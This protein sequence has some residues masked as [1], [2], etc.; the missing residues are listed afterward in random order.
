MKKLII[1]V[2]TFVAIASFGGNILPVHAATLTP[3]EQATLQQSLD[4][5]KAQLLQLESQQAAA[6]ASSPVVSGAKLSLTDSAAVNTALTS[7]AV[8]L[9]NLQ[10]TIQNNP[11]IATANAQGISLALQ[12]IGK[13]LVMIGTTVVTG[14]N[15]IAS[16]AP[17]PS[18]PKPAS[19]P[20]VAMNTPAP[21]PTP[22][23]GIQP[24][25][26]ATGNGTPA[27]T[28][29]SAAPQSAQVAQV[30]NA[31]SLK[32]IAWPYVAVG[33]LVILAIALWLWW[34]SEEEDNAKGKKIVPMVP[35]KPEQPP[36][37]ILA[38]SGKPISQTPSAPAPQT[39]LS[40]A[41]S[42]PQQTQQ[43]R[44]PA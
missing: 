41:V 1:S 32:D 10:A 19:A 31:W 23:T 33:I 3:T 24:L 38:S 29:P 13:T 26:G 34:P 25:I 7:L 14:N 36:V 9:T 11:Q 43:Q 5:M 42:A 16:T 37:T 8:A 12:G 4:A 21:T 28:T 18:S 30:S 17:A 35:A 20:S 40:A 15:S 39:P 27:A 44:K 22:S 2:W 6:Q